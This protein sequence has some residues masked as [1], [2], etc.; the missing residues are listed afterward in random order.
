MFLIGGPAF[1]GTTLLALMLNQGDLVCL[2][3]P[4]F[5]D[6][7]QGHRGIPFLQRLFPDRVFP[8]SPQRSL[9]YA[10]AVQLIAE[11]ERAITP[12]NL[13]MKTCGTTFVSY[14]EIYKE[15]GDPVI[16]ILRDIRDALVRPL[17]EFVTEASLNAGYRAVWENLHL[18]DLWVRYEDLVMDPAAV[19]SKIS[20]VLSYRLETMQSWNPASVHGQMFKLDRHELLKRGTIARDRIGVWLGSGARFSEE[21]H[22][23]AGLMGY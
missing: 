4:D 13:G 6:P 21:T 7:K 23:T 3:E 14:A 1:S 18:C 9:S 12:R 8:P 15:R 11:C 20:T 10:E 2:D 19:V 5:H 16:A 22:R 17:P